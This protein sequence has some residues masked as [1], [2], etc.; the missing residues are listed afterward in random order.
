[1]AKRLTTKNVIDKFESIHGST[2]DYSLVDYQGDSKKVKIICRTHGI[3]EQQ[4]ACHIRQ[5]QGCPRCGR[6]K[7]NNI[8]KTRLLGNNKFIE[9]IEKIFGKDIFDYN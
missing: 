4:P 1:M 3:F 2:Y 9:R 6:E 5:K 8:I 7:V